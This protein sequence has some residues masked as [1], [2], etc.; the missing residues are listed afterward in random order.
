MGLRRRDACGKVTGRPSGGGAG[1]R[2][3]EGLCEAGGRRTVLRIKT[4]EKANR[5]G[6][7]PPPPV[8]PGGGLAG[9][10]GTV[11]GRTRFP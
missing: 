10:Q 7:P 8:S 5:E 9:H 1:A 4:G 2:P 6:L 3:G 11:G